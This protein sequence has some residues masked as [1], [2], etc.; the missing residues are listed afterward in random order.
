MMGNDMMTGMGFGRFFMM[1]FWVLILVGIIFA[2]VWAVK[3]TTGMKIQKF[4]ENAIEALKKR[5]ARGEITKGKNRLL[6]LAIIL[7]TAGIVGVFITTGYSG[8]NRFVRGGGSGMMSGMMGDGMMGSMTLMTQWMNGETLPVDLDTPR[9]AQ[10]KD[11]TKAG[12]TIYKNRCAVCH[13]RKGDG[14]G[15]RAKELLTKPADFT[16]G[17][18]KFRSA[19]DIA[20]ADVDL[21]RTV[22]RGLHGTAMLPWPGL[23]TVEKWQV[24]YY[25]KTFTD[26]FED[27]QAPEFVKVPKTVRPETEYIGQGSE[28]YKK[29]RCYECHGHEGR[30]DGEKANKLKDDRQRPIRPR[31]FREQILKRGVGVEEI[32]LTIA[33]GLN[34]TPMLSYSHV[35]KEDE[36]L[37]LAFFIQSIA[38]K[39]ST[40]GMMMGM[41]KMSADERIGMMTDMPGMPMGQGMMMQNRFNEK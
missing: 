38:R 21:F 20:P 33:T 39:P 36:M 29:A 41:V 5:Y 8:S 2:L 17:I 23:T 11:S 4:D 31:N 7:F 25:I 3:I 14:N 12:G 9:P 35:L 16:S 24:V 10:N 22:S 1:I 40:G 30:G 15:E 27:E 13:G 32:Y 18:F 6:V 34:G 26:L 28:V 37:A 19:K